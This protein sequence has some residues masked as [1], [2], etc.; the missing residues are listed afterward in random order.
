[1]KLFKRKK[2][3][4]ACLVVA[5]ATALT[6]SFISATVPSPPVTGD[7]QI[8]TT[9]KQVLVRACYDCHSNET[10]L[11]WFDKLP[12]VSRLVTKDVTEARQH[13]N[14]STWNNLSVA[15]QKAA[16]WE[17][18]NMMDAG[19]MPLPAYAALHPGAKIT[20]AD[21]TV[22]RSYLDKIKAVP[23]KDTLA[24]SET[25]LPHIPLQQAAPGTQL[26]VAPNGIRHM[27]EYRNWQVMSTTSRFDNGT[28]RV[29]Y[30]NPVAI[31][32]IQ[33]GT[34]HP[35]PDGAV[36]VKVVWQKK[37]DSEGN[38]RPGK[39]VNIQYMVRDK[40]RFKDT[41]GWGFARFDAPSLK[42]YGTI[43]TTQQC[44]SCHRAVEQTGFVFDLPVK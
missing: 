5:S 25:A 41:E 39:L 42:P 7:I 4:L 17:I 1:M 18:Y 6:A 37:L 16:L 24:K 12:L 29:M 33:H 21:L 36:I 14:F 34:I 44:I 22:F 28:M 27:P 23:A 10:R 9:I 35:W 40:Q 8:D 32:A 19:R 31:Q 20:A 15:D 26:P 11:S 2:T 3:L 13:L 43:L 30:A 38:T